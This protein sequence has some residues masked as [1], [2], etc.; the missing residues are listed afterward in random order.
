MDKV[1]N[2][3]KYVISIWM[4]WKKQ[5]YKSWCVKFG[6]FNNSEDHHDA[7]IFFILGQEKTIIYNIYGWYNYLFWSKKSAPLHAQ[8]PLK[9]ANLS[10]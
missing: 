1:I 9:G 3:L 5:H 2:F 7:E 6:T 8:P 10:T 4:V